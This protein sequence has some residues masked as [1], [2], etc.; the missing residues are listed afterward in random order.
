MQLL[1]LTK[2]HLFV[3]VVALVLFVT[4]DY[5]HGT[6]PQA[7]AS[8]PCAG[9]ANP[10]A[11]EN[12]LPGSPA[13]EW[14]I[15]GAGSASIQGFATDISVN[16]GQTIRFKIDTPAAAYRLDIYRLGY[17]N[18]NGARQV[19]TVTPTATLPQSQP[20]CAND[21]T[22]GLIDCG[23]WAESASWL[24]PTTAVSGVYVAKAVRTDGTSGSSHIV[25]IVRDD[26]GRSDVLFQTSDTTWQ[27]YNQYGGNSLYVGS[28]AGRAYKVS[29]NRPFTT[30]ETSP[31]DWLFNAEYPMIRWLEANGYDVS[32]TTGV[33]SDRHG[34]ELVEHKAF[35]SVGHDEYWSGAQRANV[36]AARGAG[37]NLAFFSGNE[38]FWKT[39]WENSIDGSATS[40]RTLV[41]YKETHANAKIDP[42]SAV[43]TGTWRDPRYSPP[44]DGGRPEHALTG[45]LFTVN[46]GAGGTTTMDVPAEFGKLR[47]WRNTSVATLAPGQTATLPNGTLGYEWDESPND[48]ARPS[49][50]I[51]LSRT[52]R[53]VASKLLDYG[54]TYGAGTATHS[55][56]LYRDP[57]SRALVFG[58]GTVQWSWGLDASHDRQASVVDLRMQQAT[59]N[60]LADMGAQPATPQAG[61][62]T[63]T[64]LDDAS[65]PVSAI[66]VPAAGASVSQGVPVTIQGTASDLGGTVAL[67]EVS[68]DG[69]VTWGAATGT[70]NWSY[71]WTPA[72]RG[73]AVLVS[74]AVDDS[75][76]V[77]IAAGDVPVTIDAPAADAC[78]CSIWSASTVP[79]VPD[80]GADNPVELG[81]KFRS[82]VTGYVTGVR[83]YKSAANAGPHTGN[84]WTIG[85][86]RLATVTFANESA[87]GWQTAYFGTPV[88]I[89]ANTTYVVSYFA[90][91]GHYAFGTNYFAAGGVD[92]GR[93]HALSN[94][95]SSNGVFRYASVS[96]FPN[97]TYQA[98]NYWVDV[99]FETNVV[100]TTAPRVTSTN[101]PAA[102]A[103]ALPSRI[104]VTFDEPL[105]GATVSPSSLEL[106]D[107]SN[108]LVASSVSYDAAT[109]RASLIPASPLSYLA[110]YTAT[111]RGGASGITD[112]AGNAMASDHTWTFT[113]GAA[114]PPPPDQGP[115]G[116]ILVIGSASNAFSRYY[117]EILRAEGLNAF[118]V[119]EL[120]QVTANVLAG[121]DVVVLGNIALSSAEVAMISNWVTAGGQL[122]AMR[123]DKQLASL[124]GLTDVNATL[125]DQYLQIN[126]AAAPGTGL[127]S[128]TIQ[129]HGQADL[130][131][132]TSAF[133]LATLYA[134]STTSAG[135]PAVTLRQVGSNGGQAAAFTYDLAR[136][137][138][139]TRQGNPA[140]AGQDRD[141]GLPIRSD[142]LFF[143]GTGSRDWVDLAKVAIPQADEQQRLFAN[144]ILQMNASRRPLPRFWYL[145][146]SLKAA[147]VMTGD[148]HGNGGTAG[149]FEQFLAASPAGCSVDD[150]Q[151]IRGTSY[152]YTNT[153]LSS[154]DAA[155]Y[156]A[157]GFE[158]GLHV[159]TGCADYTASGIGSTF[160]LQL[161]QFRAKYTSLPPQA[162]NRTHCIVWSDWSSQATA[163]VQHGVRLDTNYYYW[164]AAWVNNRPGMFTGSG[165]PMRFASLSGDMIDV[166][167]AATQ[168]TDE[169][170]QTYPL[171][172]DTLLDRA[173][174]V[175]GY[176]GVFTAN[177]HTDNTAS[178]GATAIVNSALARGVP[179]ITAK[180]LLTWVDGRNASTFK[181]LVWDGA[182]LTFRIEIGIGARGLTAMVPA[183]VNG[184]PIAGITADGAPVPFAQE[185][186]KGVAYATFTA[187]SAAYRVSYDV[188]LP[189]TTIT[190]AP[191]AS[192]TVATASFEFVATQPGSTFECALDGSAFT[193]C[194]SPVTY[195]G[196]NT[197]SH[198]FSVR[199]SGIAGADPTP[200]TATWTIALPVP[201]TTI[202]AGPSGT[203]G[204][205]T[206]TFEFTSTQAGS[207]FQCALDNAVF[208]TCA[209][210]VT[211]SG[212]ADGS[213]T[214][215]VRAVSVNGIDATPATRT[216]TVAIAIP[217]TTMT[218]GPSGFS[219]SRTATFQFTA[220]IAGSTF[221][222]AMDAAAYTACASPAS[223]SALADGSHTFRVRAV[224][225]GG[226]DATPATR[227]WTVD[228]TAPAI[229]AIA[230]SALTTA[231]TV[232]WTTDE[233]SD[234]VVS[235]GTSAGS[236][237]ASATVATM[238][239]SHSVTLSGLSA[240]VTYYYRVT[241]RNAAALSA[242]STTASF[243]TR[244]VVT[245]APA[246]A[247][248]TTG[249]LRAGSA[250]NLA[251]NNGSYYQVNSS[252]SGTRTS[253]WYGAFTGV[254]RS[255]ANLRVNYS[256]MQSRSVAQ[257]IEIFR[258]SDSTWVLLNTATVGTTELAVNNLLPSGAAVNYVSTAGEVRVRVRSVAG[259]SS[260]FYTV[261]DVLQIVFD[262][263]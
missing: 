185:T 223:Y 86:T 158:V 227:T 109:T 222:C 190:A 46:A 211:Y 149:R 246:S 28:P 150:W 154:N 96:A 230:V 41:C 257:N 98:T 21:A 182:A 242:A 170:G 148:D 125:S 70:T 221:E 241:S 126:T 49:G 245:Q 259:T 42:Q 130:Y 66:S 7:Q 180:Q 29:Y 160:A 69:G 119:M 75:A 255:L 162:T 101:P 263:P 74:R 93:L 237:T 47:F 107:S 203:V 62:V 56:T 168:M 36:E 155:N 194:V 83:F 252:T 239:T 124:L 106:R 238:V 207:T 234:S 76:N 179:V 131:S 198:T 32:Y 244:T 100:D 199:A 77:E 117:A 200:A 231:A 189:D 261:A 204:V 5:G 167:Q 141:G 26:G 58:S 54:S 57:A 240:G 248:V 1:R 15:T 235:Y 191:P 55:L 217:D 213:H 128:E 112:I 14:D 95:V 161:A 63:S 88:Q 122:I 48:T 219:S 247:T 135:R 18:G 196:L 181:D 134:D 121:Y 249:S 111:V 40:Y 116:P 90:P 157:Q 140:W 184:Y 169:S 19:A 92:N 176:Y 188:P 173:L 195:S 205:R 103:V 97:S 72:A 80:G 104:E 236:L 39:R 25:F 177:M 120:S 60:L 31:E 45:T 256:G 94:A 216:W 68:V 16:R 225:T 152:I 208:A 224:G 118:A 3:F 153:P 64:A 71:T 142:D 11:C 218:A 12:T 139:Y 253:A 201:D 10:V 27:A 156:Q 8:D 175:E 147:V 110:T 251:T 30:R 233:P 132:A 85:G 20:A 187:A 115:G 65:P 105:N 113:I 138:V 193:A 108:A 214:F 81:V 22:T 164:P 165:M 102:A 254:S 146:R 89:Q 87:S 35:L 171:T 143:G 13:S 260:S 163:S 220:S 129:F 84:L 183:A 197:G 229:S 99:V 6:R 172:A 250:G 137:I 24:V 136:S 212:L 17:Y 53:A 23:V 67:V 37:V 243:A 44:A 262:R 159:N 38:V 51:A 226:T 9:A 2:H 123:P 258:W 114:P 178:A 145:P 133:T 50:L 206:A 127:V 144:L 232:T 4:T 82:D 215:S 91:T 192:S 210:P 43:W 78:P 186:I 79:A 174:G 52:T 209:T 34:G 73:N 33:D 61:L 151:C 202:N 59:L 166:Y 228:G